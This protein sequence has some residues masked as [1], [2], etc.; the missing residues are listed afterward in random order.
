MPENLA[1]DL[2]LYRGNLNQAVI[3]D[4]ASL[5]VEM[6]SD[7]QRVTP[8]VYQLAQG[9]VTCPDWD[10]NK[11]IEQ[12]LNWQ[13]DPEAC[14]ATSRLLE[15]IVKR[16]RPFV[17]LWLSP[18]QADKGETEP[19]IVLS[20]A[21]PTTGEGLRAERKVI[22]Y[23]ICVSDGAI[24]NRIKRSLDPD[25][26]YWTD[27]EPCRAKPW[28]SEESFMSLQSRLPELEELWMYLNT[29]TVWQEHGLR[30]QVAGRVVR[31]AKIWANLPPILLGAYLEQQLQQAGYPVGRLGSCGL[32]NQAML[33]TGSAGMPIWFAPVERTPVAD[34]PKV[35]VRYIDGVKECYVNNCGSCGKR[36]GL[37]MKKG[38]KC[39]NCM[40]VYPGVD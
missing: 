11:S 31:E 26:T 20:I 23:G 34:C 22:N 24:V 25:H 10:P 6:G 13:S 38:E 7:Q 35:D 16:P 21:G 5:P 15:E 14:Q 33:N 30:Q 1:F 40:G 29:N 32:S 39:P 28:F 4:L 19:R 12:I 9:R 17:S 2:S 27:K 36:L 3:H 37:W 18:P 8:Y